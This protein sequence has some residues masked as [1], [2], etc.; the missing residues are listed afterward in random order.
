MSFLPLIFRFLT[1]SSS[2]IKPELQA[3]LLER[4]S[5]LNWI[6]KQNLDP[7]CF[8]DALIQRVLKANEKIRSSFLEEVQKLLQETQEDP[9]DPLLSLFESIDIPRSVALV[10]CERLQSLRPSAELRLVL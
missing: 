8:T 10:L 3:F 6:Q 9:T 5:V 2:S 1:P 4:A 7:E